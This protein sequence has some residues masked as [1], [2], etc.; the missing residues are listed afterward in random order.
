MGSFILRCLNTKISGKKQ[1]HSPPFPPLVGSC[2]DGLRIEQVRETWWQTAWKYLFNSEAASGRNQDRCVLWIP[3]P[4]VHHPE[5]RWVQVPRC[6]WWW[7]SSDP[8]W[9]GSP[10]CTRSAVAAPVSA[11][12]A[13]QGHTGEVGVVVGGCGE[14]KR[15]GL[16]KEDCLQRSKFW[17]ETCHILKDSK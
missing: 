15:V 13:W 2:W 4:G 16:S 3:L 11:A 9:H 1:S 7:A 5:C 8:A 6:S 12:G 14:M 17:C 10:T